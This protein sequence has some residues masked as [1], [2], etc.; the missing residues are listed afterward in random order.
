M[1]LSDFP[2]RAEGDPTE[3]STPPQKS[4]PEYEG[5]Q[6]LDELPRGGQ[7]LVYKAIH[8][9]TKTKVALKVLAPG[10]LASAKARR[11]F[12]REVD[13]ISGLKHPYIVSIRDSGITAGHYYF[14]MEY[15]AQPSATTKY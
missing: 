3:L 4:F 14:A 13:I 11:R 7:A 2:S 8:K 12:E 6:I 10:Y 9:A 1:D 15:T 5:F